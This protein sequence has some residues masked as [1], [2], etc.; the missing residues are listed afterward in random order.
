[1]NKKLLTVVLC[2]VGLLPLAAHSGFVAEEGVLPETLAPK[3]A[4][5]PTPAP[6]TAPAPPEAAKATPA[7]TAAPVAAPASV[8]VARAGTTV[9]RTIEEWG[10]AADWRVVWEPD[11]LDYPIPATRTFEGS[12]QSALTELFDPYRKARRPLLV[13]GYRGNSV[14][15]VTE[16]R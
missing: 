7:A 11:D 4:P 16:K 14:V 10:R 1:M 12:F 13:D 5:E 3:K 6:V 15:V 9:R 2:V 8:W